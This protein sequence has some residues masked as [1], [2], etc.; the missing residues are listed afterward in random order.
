V[1]PLK[2]VRIG[3][4]KDLDGW[5]PEKGKRDMYGREIEERE[6][7]QRDFVRSQILNFDG[8]PVQIYKP[9]AHD[10]VVPPGAEMS[11]SLNRGSRSDT[12][13]ISKLR[14]THS[15]RALRAEKTHSQ[16]RQLTD[17]PNTR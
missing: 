1:I 11:R 17:A 2:V 7:T 14:A 16:A 10:S 4:D 3:L 9:G 8:E 5:R 13:Q 6:Y 12:A 15:Q